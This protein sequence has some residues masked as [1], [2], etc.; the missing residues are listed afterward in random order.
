MGDAG[1]LIHDEIPQCVDYEKLRDKQNK[2]VNIIM[3]HY[4]T[5]QDA[6]PLRILSRNDRNRKFIF[7][8]CNQL[9]I[10]KS[11][12]STMLSCPSTCTKGCC[13]IQH[14][15]INNSFQVENTYKR[16]HRATR[17]KTYTFPRGIIS[18]KIHIDR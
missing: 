6:S 18:Y 13:S 10:I 17:N 16:I 7:D 15:S 4:H 5:F 1:C 11:I 14:W 8:W 9:S 12:I 3:L 2:A